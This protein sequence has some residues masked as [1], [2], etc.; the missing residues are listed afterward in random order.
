MQVFVN[1]TV[2]I[3]LNTTK[4]V[5]SF[6]V[7]KIKYIDPDG[8]EGRWTAIINPSSNLKIQATIQFSKAG[9]WKVQAYVS[10]AGPEYFHGYWAEIRVYEALATTTTAAPTT[11][12]P[13]TAPPTTVAPT[14]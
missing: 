13:S 14:T 12:P 1:D 9:R 4:D 2:T 11:A 8:D 3:I 10:K 6:T 5:S 7:K